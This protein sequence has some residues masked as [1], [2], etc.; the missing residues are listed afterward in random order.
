MRWHDLLFLHWPVP[1]A[2]VRPLVPSDLA[3]DLHDGH[4]WVGVVPFAMSDVRPRRLPACPGVSAF[5]ELN[6]RTY[7]THGGR[8]GVW[9]FS[10]DATSRLAVAVARRTYHLPY[11]VARISLSRRDG[12][13][14]YTSD[15]CDL[16][17]APA[18]FTASYRPVSTPAAPAPGSLES[19][20]V[21]R[22][23]LYARSPDGRLWRGE[24]DHD[25][26]P[27]QN[28]EVEL[29]RETTACAAGI[30]PSGPAASRLYARRLDV[31][32]WR[33]TPV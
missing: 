5:A 2:A 4:A 28:A 17:A 22:Y 14:Y 16:R 18:T 24:I 1:P 26:W 10:L 7:V 33:L 11:L 13:V 8:P 20:L 9:F 29:E 19:F 23:C 32:A 27:L 3:L 31:V 12:A 30:G 21:D 6:V 25:P 15:R